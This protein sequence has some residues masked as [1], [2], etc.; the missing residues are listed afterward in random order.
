ML[1]RLEG[2]LP[3]DVTSSVPGLYVVTVKK[4]GG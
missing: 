4:D 1:R 3:I 2:Q